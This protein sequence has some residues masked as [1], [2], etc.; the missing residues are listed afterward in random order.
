MNK[1]LIMALVAGVFSANSNAEGINLSPVVVTATKNAVNSFD[2][3]V[4]I[5]VVDKSSIQD[6]QAQMVLS[7]SLIRVPGITAQN[8]TQFSQDPQIS[9]RGFGSRSSF[10]V[11]GLRIYVDGIPFSMPDG[12][13]QP[14]NIDLNAV[15]SIEVMRGPFSSL[16]GSSSGG[17]IQ[18]LTEDSPKTPL[19][20]SGGYMFGSYGTQKE[21]LRASGSEGNFEYL[22]NYSKF[23][24]DGY[25]ANSAAN[26]EQLTAKLKFNITDTTKVTV[27]AN[28]MD[29][30]AQDPLGLKRVGTTAEPSAFATPKAVPTSAILANTR[31]SRTNTQAGINLEQVV[32]ENNTI[33]LIAYAGKRDNLQYL[34]LASNSTSGRAS[35]ISR[36]FWGTELRWSNKGELLSR[37]YSITSG[38]TY[39]RMEDNRKDI[40]ATA[41]VMLDE[42]SLTNVNRRE[43]NIA[44]NFD[45]YLQ[46]QLG[47]LDNLDIHAGVRHTK[48]NLKVED[49]LV[50]LSQ[51]LSLSA[52]YKYKDGSGS[53][54]YDK[55]TPVIGATWKVNPQFNLYANYGKGFETPTLIEVAYA[56]AN[57]SGPNLGLKPSTSDNYEIGAKAFLGDIARVN[58]AVFRTDTEG[59]LVTSQSGTY[60]V[61]SNAGKTKRQG[62]ELSADANLPNNF[63]L[64]GA[65]TYLDAKFTS[66]YLSSS[67]TVK[68]GNKIPG[69]YRTQIYGELS[70]KAPT[71]G[72]STALEARYNS[73]VFVDDINT[74][75]APSYT[76]FNL[77]AVL[78]QEV[79]KWRFS[80]YVRVE[81]LFD[82]DYIGSVRVNDSNSRFFEAAPGRNYLMGV[83]ATYRF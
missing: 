73:K 33:N 76:V 57:G 79:Q 16:Y 82:K 68:T 42:S 36:D 22:V 5:D 53:V 71:V 70:W 30:D 54:S 35:S 37:P 39:G 75:S 43:N 24:T 61:Y 81:N 48:V 74:D 80:E 77:R 41:G 38:L 18:L 13:G 25:R 69:T 1:K 64:Y 21:T 44:F 8:R 58:A 51:N 27:M 4:S 78:Q 26:K 9:T 83:N 45:Q 72:F 7:E 6:G 12:I 19:E 50:D 55:T 67:N 31:V 63:G 20:L 66:D 46:G 15:K 17:V 62:L 11:R 40:A 2:I 32:N 3:P 23:E 56:D 59:E 28:W 29:M 14:G 49:N 52:N 60:A 65:Y 47:L 10:G 34:S